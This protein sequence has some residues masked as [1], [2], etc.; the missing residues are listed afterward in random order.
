MYF[1]DP[2]DFWPTRELSPV[3]H[4][5]YARQVTESFR[6]G[7]YAEYEEVKFSDNVSPDTFSFSRFNLG[8]DWLGQFP[9]TPLHLQL[10]GYFGYGLLTADNW[11]NLKGIDLGLIA[12]PAFETEHFGVAVHLQSGHA[13]YESTGSPSGVML[14]T[15][16]FLLK[17]YYKL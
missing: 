7:G 16:R 1:D 13:W 10:G 12:G 3:A 9:K 4:I 2:F 11:D 17:I 5:F 14:Y 15:P 6:I 8:V